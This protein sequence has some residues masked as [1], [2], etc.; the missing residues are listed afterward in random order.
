M[1]IF[2]KKQPEFDVR[3]FSPGDIVMVNGKVY[4]VG[5]EGLKQLPVK[6]IGEE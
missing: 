1:G 3:V 5:A 2:R 6:K 4:L